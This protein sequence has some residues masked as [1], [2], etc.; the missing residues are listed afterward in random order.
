MSPSVAATTN[1]APPAWVQPR[2]FRRIRRQ[3]R[4][5]RPNSR[6]RR[7]P[8]SSSRA[9]RSRADSPR[10]RHA[11][12]PAL[13]R[14]HGQL[15]RS[16]ATAVASSRRRRYFSLHRPS[17]Q[18]SHPRTVSSSFS[19]PDMVRLDPLRP[20]G[21]PLITTKKCYFVDLIIMVLSTFE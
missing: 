12:C 2:R 10:R 17:W 19:D 6:W 1:A 8:S 7:H 16:S 11:V 13:L 15:R 5:P 21:Q 18:Q 3:F 14:P 9:L 20:G 4:R